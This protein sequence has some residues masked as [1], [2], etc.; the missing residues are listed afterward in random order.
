MNYSRE[1]LAADSS[2]YKIC[3]RKLSTAMN[4]DMDKHIKHFDGPR[5]N[6]WW[7][8][9]TLEKQNYK[10]ASCDTILALL[11]YKCHDPQ[12]FII[13]RLNND[14][15]HRILNCNIVCLKCN[16]AQ[17]KKSFSSHMNYKKNNG[18]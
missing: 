3:S 8:L 13:N 2:F 18:E 6:Y 7:I 16:S 9:H 5:V 17:G 10:C 14:Y 12:Q 11:N 1:I 4:A 15:D